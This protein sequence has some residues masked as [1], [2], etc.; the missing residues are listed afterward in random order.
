MRAALAAVVL[1]AVLAHAGP[2]RYAPPAIPTPPAD[3]WVLATKTAGFGWKELLGTTGVGGIALDYDDSSVTWTLQD[4][5]LLD[6]SA[7][8]G[9]GFPAL[10]AA[11]DY[12][13]RTLAETDGLDITNPAGVAGN[14]T[15]ALD[16]NEL[17]AET[18]LQTTDTFPFYDGSATAHRKM[19]LATLNAFLDHGALA[20]LGDDDH[21][22]YALLAGRSGGQAWTCGTGSGDDCTL[23]ST[24]H[25][26][27]GTVYVQ[28]GT[29]NTPDLWPALAIDPV[30]THTGAFSIIYGVQV[31]S[32]GATRRTWTVSGNGSTLSGGLLFDF[33]P[34]VKNAAGAAISSMGV[35][36]GLVYRPLFQSD[37]ASSGSATYPENAAV[38]DI[39]TYSVV[40][41]GTLAATEHTTVRAAPTINTGSTL[42]TRRGLY[43]RDKSG[44]GAQTTSV[45]L[46]IENQTTGTLGL[47]VR[48]AGTDDEMRHAGPAV[49]G[50]NAQPTNPTKTALQAAGGVIF[51]RA[52][53]SN[54]A[55][56]IDNAAGFGD[57]FVAQVGTMSAS[58]T[59]TLP[60]AST[61]GAGRLVVVVDE[62]GSV[63]GTNTIVVS[64]AGSD[65]IN[66]ATTQTIN[67][68]Y[69]ILRLV[70]DGTSKW[71]VI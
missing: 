33:S 57:T 41:S 53:F 69:G 70:S 16:F 25:A 2:P 49:F 40:N 36:Q 6:L 55:Y 62:S 43:Y 67:A 30:L 47:S 11:E 60:A 54:A 52:T 50:A 51:R 38:V 27:R 65:T 37:G 3:G 19:T 68:A 7:L 66:G 20:G 17:T 22:I 34:T 46:D 26:S 29:Y 45:A 10:I 48:S 35:W 8:S 58:R 18:S 64:R 1:G 31:G 59:V 28:S 14:P 42:T 13:L 61:A 21:T 63:T 71:T 4:P 5:T 44:S 32:D 24:S 56:T 12:A 39:P 23:Q 9:T 15:F